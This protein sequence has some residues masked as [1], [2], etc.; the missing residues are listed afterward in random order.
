MIKCKNKSEYE[1]KSNNEQY[2]SIL[3]EIHVNNKSINIT[4]L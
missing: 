2:E 3:V 1:N 4:G